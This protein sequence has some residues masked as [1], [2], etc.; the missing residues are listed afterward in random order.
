MRDIWLFDLARGGKSRFTF[1]PAD[2]I[3]SVWSKDGGRIFF[4]SDRKG[5]RDIF[6]KKVNAAED[7]ELIFASSEAKNVEDLSPD[8]RLLIYNTNSGGL[9]LLPLEGE[10]NPKPFLKTQFS[11]R[12]AVISPDGRWVAYCS[13]ESGRDEI[14]VATFPQLS[15][16][17]QASVDGGIEP[18]W[19]GDGK[20]L[21]F[22][23]ATR[24]L[25]AVEVK[26]GSGAFEAKAPKLLFETQLIT[27]PNRNRYVVTGDGQRFLVITRLENTRAPIS[28][29]VNWLA[30]LKQ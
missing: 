18:Q 8:G 6:Q 17:W 11:E 26:P 10:R 22:T 3:N 25:M 1:D 4:T 19:R 20:E 16:K 29:V 12:M 13:D 28:V 14:Y 27:P 24:K 9:W 2:D 23:N 15:G 5:Q 30:E 7:E 21:F